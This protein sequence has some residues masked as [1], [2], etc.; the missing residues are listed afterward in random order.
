MNEVPRPE[1]P[2]STGKP[3]G[4]RLRRA[5]ISHESRFI[6]YLVLGFGVLAVLTVVVLAMSGRSGLKTETP[7]SAAVK[8]ISGGLSAVLMPDP[9]KP[10][11]P[12]KELYFKRQP[13]IAAASMEGDWQS[14]I[15][16][17]TAVL[18]LKGGVYQIILANAD[19]AAARLYSQGT[20]KVQEDV[21]LL[22]PR[23][24]WPKPAT[25]QKTSVEYQPITRAPFPIIA[26]IQSGKMLWQNPPQS[27][28]R[29]L[30]PY[31]SPLLLNGEADYIVWQKL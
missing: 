28:R 7:N 22:T 4:Q 21:L 14:M 20:Y 31:K 5:P 17:Y 2:A 8:E 18:Q 24:D 13:D 30:V 25:T 27:E 3:S 9:V 6:G 11:T 10:A 26:A 1:R 19:P 16:K 15:G 12:K 29:V 23:L